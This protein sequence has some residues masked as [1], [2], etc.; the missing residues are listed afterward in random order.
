M[1]SSSRFVPCPICSRQVALSLIND[2]IDSGQCGPVS[3]EPSAPFGRQCPVQKRPAQPVAP[4]ALKAARLTSVPSASAAA[5]PAKAAAQRS[6]LDALRPARAA[7]F[8]LSAQ[9]R[10]SSSSSW[11]DV[12]VDELRRLAPL[13]LETDVL[14]AA[15]AT[16]LLSWLRDDAAH[17]E[18][19][20]WIVHGTEGRTAPRCWF[21]LGGG[22]GGGGDG[23]GGDGDGGDGGGG[24]GGGGGGDSNVSVYGRYSTRAPSAQLEDAAAAVAALVRRLR[25][26]TASAWA[27]SGALANRYADGS[28][29]V[30]MHSDFINMLGPRPIIVGLSL[31]AARR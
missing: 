11:R 6:L 1:A 16:A 15:D 10:A 5:A 20:S 25:P 31:G 13:T 24:E 17:W 21:A 14:P 22:D 18:R 9:Y 28:V 12:Q 23:G 29:Q 8:H 3:E 26:A 2:H 19:G 27:P 4:G 30:G 7:A